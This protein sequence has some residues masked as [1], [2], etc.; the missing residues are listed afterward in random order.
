MLRADAMRRAY[1]R[2]PDF[3]ALLER[4]DPRGA[5]RNRWLETHVLGDGAVA[6]SAR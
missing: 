2:L 4:L 3:V 6:R 5:F 1:A